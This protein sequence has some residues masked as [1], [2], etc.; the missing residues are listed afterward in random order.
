VTAALATTAAHLVG[1]D[2]IDLDV[3]STVTGTTRQF[4]SVRDLQRDIINARVWV[5][6]HWRTSD[7]IGYQLGR[8]VA[9]WGISHHFRPS[10]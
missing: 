1:G 9:Q 3:N 8:R 10:H 4:R 7:E 5:G 2:R 6:Y